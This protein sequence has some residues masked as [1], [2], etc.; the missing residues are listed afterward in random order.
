METAQQQQSGSENTE[1]YFG[2]NKICAFCKR[3]HANW[4]CFGC[5]HWFHHGKQSPILKTRLQLDTS[6][7]NKKVVTCISC[8][9]YMHPMMFGKSDFFDSAEFDNDKIQEIKNQANTKNTKKKNT[10]RTSTT[11]ST[12][13]ETETETSISAVETRAQQSNITASGRGRSGRTDGRGMS[14]RNN[15]G[16]RFIGNRKRLRR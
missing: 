8:Y 9:N 5:H 3:Q 10:K 11:L 2:G 16:G 13:T 7:L 4:Y 15:Q 14:T 1:V 6:G 12:I